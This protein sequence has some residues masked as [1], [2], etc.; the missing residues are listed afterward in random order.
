MTTFS[1]SDVQ[2]V[3]EALGRDFPC[4]DAG[5]ADRLEAD[6]R[7]ILGAL[8]D[9]GRLAPPGA[10]ERVTHV[11]AD[12]EYSDFRVHAAFVRA[13][14]A[15]T[16]CQNGAGGEVLELPLYGP[17][18]QPHR[19]VIYSAAAQ[20]D[21]KNPEWDRDLWITE[22]A[23]WSYDPENKALAYVTDN[24]DPVGRRWLHALG[25]DREAVVKSVSDRYAKARAE[26][27]GL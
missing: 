26:R 11:L 23:S 1:D 25:T 14:D 24:T 18:E 16:A 5:L 13:E 6:A 15:E 19:I 17:G 12:G 7:A 8:A 27:D 3:A 22:T 2:L 9:A 20:V 4:P 21:L 10:A